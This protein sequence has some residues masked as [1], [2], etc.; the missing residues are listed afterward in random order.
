M[1]NLHEARPKRGGRCA[2]GTLLH[3]FSPRRPM[4]RLLLLF[5]SLLPVAA[6][7]SRVAVEESGGASKQDL[8]FTLA[9]PFANQLE[10]WK[11]DARVS[12]GAKG[13]SNT[14]VRLDCCALSRVYEHTL[15]R[16]CYESTV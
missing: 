10:A 15:K 9:Y 14:A 13:N 4:P 1:V 7:V 8:P 3:L 6:L 11:E 16:Y 12:S 2:C 5:L